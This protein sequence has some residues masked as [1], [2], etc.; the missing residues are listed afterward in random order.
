MEFDAATEPRVTRCH[1]LRMYPT[2][3]QHAW[4][5]RWFKDTRTTYNL[6]MGRVLERKLHKLHPSELKL[7]E[8]EKE[9]QRDL[10]SKKG[11][12]DHLAPRHHTLLRTPKVPRQQAVKSVLAVLKGHHTRVLKQEKLHKLYPNA[13][14]FKGEIKFNPGLK[15]KKIKFAHDSFCVESV[16]LNVTA[17]DTVSFYKNHKVHKSGDYLFR[18]IRTQK[19]M[20]KL[21]AAAT[22]QDFKVHYRHGKLYLILPE[23]QRPKVRVRVPDGGEAVAAI[24]PGV[25]TAFTVYS[26]EGSVV[27]L[28]T[29]TCRV[30]DKLRRR[31][32]RTKSEL[33]R[34]GNAVEVER[35]LLCSDRKEK[36]QQR[37][38]LRRARNA[39]HDAE[40]KA[41]RVVRD[42]HYKASHYLLQRF[43]TIILPNTSSYKWREGRKLHASTKQRTMML[44]HGKF[45]ERLVQ[46]ATQYQGS[47]ILRGSEA[48]T[49]KQCGACGVINDK[50][51]ASKVFTCHSCG[52]TG[53]RDIHAARNILLRFLS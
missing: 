9:F 7:S 11:V 28:G 48:Y 42:F 26:P 53:D 41:K 31:I 19:G 8:L 35:I 22:E 33:G 3:R 20:R 45:A 52:A 4:L 2:P 24:D 18:S 50:L 15:S 14:A 25:R 5:M 36:K 12:N 39:Y 49:S 21:P 13:R 23:R 6:A 30:L 43:H 16:S 47:R 17:D 44:R 10:V 27:E 40:D 46:T 32:D 34:V 38:R 1:M 51:G 37:Q 29:N